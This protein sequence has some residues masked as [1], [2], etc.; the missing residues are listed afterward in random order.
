MNPYIRKRF[1]KDSPK[2]GA[3]VNRLYHVPMI[4]LN[5]LERDVFHVYGNPTSSTEKLT[6]R[7][8]LMSV[9][10]DAKRQIALHNY[11]AEEKVLKRIRNARNLNSLENAITHAERHGTI[12]APANH[13]LLRM[14]KT[15]SINKAIAE[16]RRRL[17]PPPRAPPPS[18]RAP[19]AFFSWMV[20]NNAPPPTSR[21]PPPPTPRSPPPSTSRAPRAFFSWMVN[22]APRP[23]YFNNVTSVR[24]LNSTMRKLSLELHP[25]K[26]GNTNAFQ[27]MRNQ[28]ERKKA[29]LSRT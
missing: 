14:L 5:S 19:R 28:Y 25:N 2:M 22:N 11:I 8:F 7:E 13:T 12:P 3:I 17:A 23:Q 16:A 27:A 1:K 4:N 20:N 21:A 29:Q 24:N 18:S 10:P 6:A 26:G 15:A 9:F